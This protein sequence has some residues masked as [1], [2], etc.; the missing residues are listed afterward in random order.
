MLRVPVPNRENGF[1]SLYRARGLGRDVRMAV[2]P[3]DAL[4]F[5]RENPDKNVI[6]FAVGFET[7]APHTAALILRAEAESVHNLSVLCAHKTMPAALTALLLNSDRV[8]ALLC[9]GH[10]AA[11]IG[12]DAF[13]FVPEVLGIPA[14]VSGFEVSEIARGASIS[15]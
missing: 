2:S 15:G 5:A 14:A 1:D 4:R 11:V 9:P 10:V 7:T 8:D 13:R 6:W 3:I 12:A